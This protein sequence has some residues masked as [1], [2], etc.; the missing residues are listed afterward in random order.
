M[1]WI[2]YVLAAAA[3]ISVAAVLAKMG[4]KKADTAL[5]AGLF[6]TVILIGAFLLARGSISISQIAS[7]GRNTII[8]LILAGL[9]TGAAILCFFKAIQT[10]EVSH[11]VPVVQINT[12]LVIIFG[13]V[14]WHRKLGINSIIA[15]ICCVGGIVV[16]LVGNTKNWQWF[17]YAL[18][19]A[20]FIT[21]SSILESVWG[22]GISSGVILFYKLIIAAILIWAVAFASGS[23]KKLRAISFLDGIYIC[24]AGAFVIL[25]N[26]F[27]S[28]SRAL[29]VDVNVLWI[30][31]TNLFIT[32][33][34]AAM[35][36]KEKISGK[37]LIGAVIFIAGLEVLLLNR[38]LF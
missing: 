27:L 34:L 12:I 2:I 1:T 10:G 32:M 33:I 8:F 7:F 15:I 6:T 11:V 26:V 21:A 3:F 13:V 23:G 24:L 4:T 5:A 36:L 38:P 19:S 17:G 16:I 9:T 20:V 14:Y 22:K 37:K 29:A 18:L 30:Y 28:R 25:T 35:I 31:R